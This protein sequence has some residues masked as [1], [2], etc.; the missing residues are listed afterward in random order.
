METILCPDAMKR[1]LPPPWTPFQAPIAPNVM[2]AQGSATRVPPPLSWHLRAPFPPGGGS[3]RHLSAQGTWGRCSVTPGL[4]SSLFQGGGCTQSPTAV[5]FH[6]VWRQ[7][8]P[9]TCEVSTWPHGSPH[10]PPGPPV[11]LQL[12]AC[13]SRCAMPAGACILKSQ[14]F[15]GN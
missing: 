15:A 7:A 9:Q 4:S 12:S 11:T 14:A 5:R 6:G 3:S 10:L 1:H 13:S 8:L 2:K